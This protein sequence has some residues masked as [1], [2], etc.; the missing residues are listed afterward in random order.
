MKLLLPAILS[1][2]LVL[3]GCGDDNSTNGD[4]PTPDQG[5]AGVPP[6]GESPS[7]AAGSV[8][9]SAA[10]SDGN[11]PGIPPLTGEIVTTASGLRYIDEAVGTGAVPQTG[12]T[13]SV[14]YTGWLTDGTQFDTSRDDNQPIQFPLGMRRVIPGWDEGL[15]SMLVGGKR[16]LII[17]TELA[18]AARG[19]APVIPSNAALIFDVELVGVQ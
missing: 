15:A 5:N 8:L 10:E 2:T 18:Y 11:A 17:P 9:P 3:T 6:P 19:S 14:Q 1:A 4:N 7:A 16:R 13:V 12:Q